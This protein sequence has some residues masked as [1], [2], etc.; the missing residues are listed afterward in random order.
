MQK[1]DRAYTWC[2][3]SGKK[4]KMFP[5]KTQQ[6]WGEITRRNL[7]IL[8]RRWFVKL[9]AVGYSFFTVTSYAAIPCWFDF[10][11]IYG[12]LVSFVV[13]FPLPRGR[14]VDK[15][16]VTY[17]ESVK[18]ADCRPGSQIT[19]PT[20]QVSEK[21][22]DREGSVDGFLADLQS[23]VDIKPCEAPYTLSVPVSH[24]HCRMSPL[25]EVYWLK[26]FPHRHWG[27]ISPMETI[28]APDLVLMP[29]P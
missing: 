29:R 9:H 14:Y 2:Q 28:T 22:I 15:N 12:E 26:H 24:Q 6:V 4:N 5:S 17:Y 25:K 8:T 7:A 27:V 10:P 21:S 13:L 16:S 3:P 23:T 1:C 20:K 19:Q 11:C 18:K